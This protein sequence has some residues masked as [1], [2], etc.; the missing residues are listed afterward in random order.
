MTLD[1]FVRVEWLSVVN[2]ANFPQYKHLTEQT[3]A[4]SSARSVA[5][6]DYPF[7]PI[8][9]IKSWPIVLVPVNDEE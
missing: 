3:V 7:A 5:N 4:M 9:N 2:K 8:I 6:R 1:G